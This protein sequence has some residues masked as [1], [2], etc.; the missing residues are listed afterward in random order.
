MFCPECDSEYR[1]GVY[2]CV[3]CQVPLVREPPPPKLHPEND[4]PADEVVV[5][6]STES[7]EA[8]L[9]AGALE[10]AGI[11]YSIRAEMAGGFR[12]SLVEQ[13]WAP[14]QWRVLSVPSIAEAR[15][16]E[17]IDSLG[18][19]EELVA[20]EPFEEE[21]NATPRRS[22]ARMV[23]LAVLVPVLAIFLISTLLM[24]SDCF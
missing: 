5:F 10:E 12:Q 2:T 20:S 18:P 13:H 14:G 22:F 17:V 19:P 7:F 9:I 23:A 4:L 21:P 6:R 15:A 24:M 1:E 8:D 16:R 3:D 11:A